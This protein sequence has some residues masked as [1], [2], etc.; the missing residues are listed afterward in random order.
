MTAFILIE[1][2]QRILHHFL[3]QTC[4]GGGA[5]LIIPV[6]HQAGACG[7]QL[8]DDDVL[9]QANQMVDLAFLSLLIV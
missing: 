4:L 3:R 9:L 8:T 2:V 7:D 1:L 5:G 6:C